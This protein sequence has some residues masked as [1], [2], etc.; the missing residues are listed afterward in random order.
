WAQVDGGQELGAR[1]LE[2]EY[3]D[4][5]ADLEGQV[6]HEGHE[7]GEDFGRVEFG[8]DHVGAQ[9]EGDS[10]DEE[11]LSG[12]QLARVLEVGFGLALHTGGAV[13]L[14]DL[15]GEERGGG[16]GRGGREEQGVVEDV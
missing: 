4:R 10:L 9:G 13:G 15:L 1:E 7:I 6:L 2:G 14:T 11:A 5:D 12:G 3:P 16:A 8:A